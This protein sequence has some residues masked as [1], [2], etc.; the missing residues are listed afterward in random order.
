MTGNRRATLT[1][2]FMLAVMF[3]L[4]APSILAKSCG[5][6]LRAKPQRRKGGESF[7]PLPLPATPLRRTEKKRPPAPP[8][9]VAKIQYGQII[10]TTDAQGNKTSYRDWTTDP[11]DIN[12]LIKLTNRALGI[13]YRPIHTTFETCTYNPAEV[14]ILYLTGHEPFELNDDQRKKLYWFINDGG[15]LIGD[16]CCGSP[17]FFD[18]F[19]NE[20]KT[21]FPNRP[22][23]PLPS[24]HPIFSCNSKITKVAIMIEGEDAGK[25]VPEIYGIDMGCR[26]AVFISPFD[27]SCG[28]DGH[29]HATGKR[30]RIA[31]ARAVGVNM[32]T[33]VLANYQLARFLSTQRVYHQ[34]G[35]KTRDEF[36][37]AQVVHDGDWD[38]CPNGIMSLLR[39][40]ASNS[41][42]PIQFKRA[43]VSLGDPEIL[44]H[45]VLYMTGH[46][47]FTLSD[48]E[49]AGLRNYLRNGGVLFANACC[50]RMEFEDA[51]RRELAK[52]VP[53]SALQQLP[54]DHPLYTAC[55][56]VRNVRYS[57][58]LRAQ[59]P[60]LARPTIEAV[61][62]S[63]QAAVIYSRYGLG[64]TWDG[65][66]RP[67]AL[68]YEPEDALRLGMNVLVYAMT[69]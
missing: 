2:I 67:Y 56:P 11:N 57:G 23:R 8:A 50:G 13:Q 41:T 36:V 35:E 17:E 54:L 37:F 16:A 55:I 3:T 47:D 66:E 12:N 7:P 29:E 64:T 20:M 19:I 42:L 48:K 38:P 65:Q 44:Q 28:W 60:D 24:D 6:P 61:I 40:T 30:I 43:A 34:E 21:I 58:P 39:Y 25:Q 49:I 10:W 33:Y 26:T 15:T 69:H 5:P 52:A 68:A 53:E 59:Q 31:D 63:G 9:L 22:L 45:P 46:N 4:D 1:L 51:F 32:M 14:P 27:L 18:S 62:L